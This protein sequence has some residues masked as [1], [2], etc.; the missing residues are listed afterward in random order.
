MRTTLT[1]EEDVAVKLKKLSQG[2]RMKE[3]ANRALRLGLQAMESRE[4]DSPY[5]TQPCSGKP[6][7]LNLD[8]VADIIAENEEEAWR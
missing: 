4:L 5:V 8:N 1:L 6:R 7:S 3:V 2:G